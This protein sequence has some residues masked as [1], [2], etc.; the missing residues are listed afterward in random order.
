VGCPRGRELRDS[1]ASAR[2][3]LAAAGRACAPRGRAV[4]ERSSTSISFAH[5]QAAQRRGFRELLEDEDGATAPGGARVGWGAAYGAAA[6]KRA[7]RHPARHRVGVRAMHG[8]PHGGAPVAA[9][10]ALAGRGRGPCDR[11]TTVACCTR[12]ASVAPRHGRTVGSGGAVDADGSCSTLAAAPVNRYRSASTAG[13]LRLG[14]QVRSGWD[15]TTSRSDAR[16]EAEPRVTAAGT[17]AARWAKSGIEGVVQAK[18]LRLAAHGAAKG[19][20]R[21]TLGRRTSPR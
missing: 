11:A 6:R 16:L 14:V 4:D 18:W 5:S 19:G 7:Q 15:R 2:K 3:R 1:G 12:N 17:A 10:K 20:N 8:G 21:L 9:A 13:G